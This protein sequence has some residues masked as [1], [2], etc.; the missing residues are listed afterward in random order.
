M[1]LPKRFQRPFSDRAMGFFAVAFFVPS[2][3]SVVRI[4]AKPW[5]A[6]PVGVVALAGGL[7]AALRHYRARSTW[8]VL[9]SPDSVTIQRGA[10]SRTIAYTE[11]EKVFWRGECHELLSP[12]L[13]QPGGPHSVRLVLKDGESLSPGNTWDQKQDLARELVG[14]IEATRRRTLDPRQD[15]DFGEVKLRAGAI[16]VGDKRL[17]PRTHCEVRVRSNTVRFEPPEGRA[18]NV[19][20]QWV[21]HPGLVEELVNAKPLV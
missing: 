13:P 6:W 16:Y 14:A 1:E 9:V 3:F 12:P 4:F 20:L 11:V 18:I 19:P 2:A 10:D 21:S 8:A 17:P 15:V 7:L 5:L